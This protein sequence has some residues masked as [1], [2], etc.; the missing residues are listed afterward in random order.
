M[1]PSKTERRMM[2]GGGGADGLR[3]GFSGCTYSITDRVTV[4]YNLIFI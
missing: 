1:K 2:G 4:A 3:A